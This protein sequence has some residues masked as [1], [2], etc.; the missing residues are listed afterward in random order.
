MPDLLRKA[1]YKYY[2]CKKYL[3]NM[4]VSHKN[5]AGQKGDDDDADDDNDGREEGRGGH[6]IFAHNG[7]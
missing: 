3:K 5:G 1:S 2:K 7:G 4:M 6:K